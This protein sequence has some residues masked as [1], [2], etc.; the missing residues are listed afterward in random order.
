MMSGQIAGAAPRRDAPRPPLSPRAMT[1]EAPMRCVARCARYAARQRIFGAQDSGERL[2]ELA[3][4]VVFLS[5]Y[6]LDGRRQIVH[7]LRPGDLFGFGGATQDCVAEAS[8]DSLVR[9]YNREWVYA[10]ASMAGRA[11]TAMIEEV[12]RLRDHMALL[13][14]RQAR[15]RV[16]GFIGAMATTPLRD[17]ATIRLDLTRGEIADYL[18]LNA[19]TVSRTFSALRKRGVIAPCAGGVTVLA[20]QDLRRLAEG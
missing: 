4:G 10:T 8:V 12:R 14:G 11:Q 15:A 19:E 13:V 18:D 3:Q 17:G 2:Y 5:R 20:A 16:A 1:H 9:S 7:I 6:R